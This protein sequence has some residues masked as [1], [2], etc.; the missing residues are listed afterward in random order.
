MTAYYGL[1][2]FHSQYDNDARNIFT[3]E[4]LSQFCEFFVRCAGIGY[5]DKHDAKII[6]PAIFENGTR[7]NDNVIAY[8]GWMALDIDRYNLDTEP[9]GYLRER[10]HDVRYVMHSTGSSTRGNPKFRLIVPLDRIIHRDDI[11]D[12]YMGLN[13]W[14][15]D[16]FGDD[17]MIDEVTHDPA[18]IYWLPGIYDDRWNFIDV[19]DGGALMRA[20]L[21]REYGR[22]RMPDRPRF[23]LPDKYARLSSEQWSRRKRD[24][25]EGMT[26]TGVT[27]TKW[28]DCVFWPEERAAAYLNKS[29]DTTWNAASYQIIL[30]IAFNAFRADY[31]IT[32]EQVAGLFDGFDRE[33][34][35]WYSRRNLLHESQNAIDFALDRLAGK[36]DLGDD[37]RSRFMGG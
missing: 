15:H 25:Y 13:C 36:G 1:T 8:G 23:R 19:H 37:Y 28:S 33:H 12:I 7:N 9:A 6:S 14:A 16:R 29:P 24:I 4:T 17:L 20:G 32:A 21:M 5:A 2:L 27:W 30:H 35:H 18:R 34:G 31:P 26:N 10:L 11:A 22:Q 3:L